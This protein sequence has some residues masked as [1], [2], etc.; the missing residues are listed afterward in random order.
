MWVIF[1]KANIS[2]ITKWYSDSWLVMEGESLTLSSVLNLSHTC[3][4]PSINSSSLQYK[5][6]GR[7][8]LM[9]LHPINVKI[10]EL[11]KQAVR[12]LKWACQ[13]PVVTVLHSMTELPI[14]S[15]TATAVT[16]TLSPLTCNTLWLIHVTG[17]QSHDQIQPM[18]LADSLDWLRVTPQP[19]SLGRSS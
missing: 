5:S 12:C 17:H 18:A 13:W 19:G 7:Q 15:V 14:H 10:L 11:E 16:T 8:Y 1:K 2:L 6:T 9:R 4:M 3:D